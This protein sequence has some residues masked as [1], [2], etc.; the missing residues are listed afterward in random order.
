M[1][2][3]T[4]EQINNGELECAWCGYKPERGEK[5]FQYEP[6]GRARFFCPQCHKVTIIEI[7]ADPN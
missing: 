6:E 3:M 7:V 1:S 2:Y 4:G 5:C